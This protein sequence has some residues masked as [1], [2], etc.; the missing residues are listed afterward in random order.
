MSQETQQETIIVTA[1]PVF[2]KCVYKDADSNMIVIATGPQEGW[3][4]APDYE[5]YSDIHF[6]DYLTN[7]PVFTDKEE[8]E[9]F[10]GELVICNP[11]NP[12]GETSEERSDDAVS[13]AT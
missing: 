2:V 10:K 13:N 4:L 12:V 11:T 7:L 9:Y 3:V 8:W 1:Q 5:V 6:G